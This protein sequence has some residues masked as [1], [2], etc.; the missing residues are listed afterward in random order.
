MMFEND[1]QPTAQIPPN[2]KSAGVFHSVYIYVGFVTLQ[3]TLMQQTVT[4]ICSIRN[5]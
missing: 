5:L 2:L 4:T 1:L 3:N